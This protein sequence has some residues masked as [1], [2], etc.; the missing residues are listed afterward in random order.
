MPVRDAAAAEPS[1]GLADRAAEAVAASVGLPGGLDPPAFA[2]ALA[3]VGAGALRHPDGLARALVRFSTGAA[4]AAVEIAATAAGLDIEEPIPADPADRRFADPAWRGNP[5]FHAAR[6]VH[7]LADRLLRDV[8]AA[9]ELDP[10]WD[11]KAQLVAAAVAAAA[12][13]SNLPVTNPTVLRRA[14]DTGGRSAV[15]GLRNLVRDVVTNGGRPSQV[16]RSAFR[17]GHDLAATPG[18]VV[19]RNDLIELLQ[20]AP[21]TEQVHATPVLL[22]PPLINKYYVMDLAPGRSFAEW[23]VRHGHTVFAISY[24]N[25]DRSWSETTFEEYLLRGPVAAVDAIGELTGSSEVDVVG[26]CQG[27]TLAAMLAAYLDAGGDPRIRSLTLLVA[28]VDFS[29]PGVL[30]AFT[31]PRSVGRLIR[32]MQRRGYLDSREMLDTFDLLRPNDLL[33]NYVVSG[34]LLG[35]DPPAYD[36]LAWNA[37]GTRLPAAAHAQY[38]TWCY[39]ENRLAQGELEVAGRRLR[40]DARARDHYVLGAEKDHVV[41]W[42]TAFATTRLVR[43]DV[44]FVLGGSGH[45]AGIVK[46]PV[47][48]T[49]SGTGPRTYHWAGP[50]PEGE[51]DAWLAAAERHERSW[52]EDWATWAA[53][54]SSGWC[55]PPPPAGG[56]GVLGDAPGTYVHLV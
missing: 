21:R 38:L 49:V 45:I 42:R 24:R 16:D 56:G 2:Q 28:P 14:F 53:E 48:A 40:L 44:R 22:S 39:V 5:W 6:D 55:A 25:P 33:W 11:R 52:W 20:Y 15:L 46:P 23:A 12:A 27:G 36:V 31:D 50:A 3:R 34:W 26:L 8:V 32:R 35:E 19:Y 18:W 41:P 10:P 29:D 13:P 7:L 47:P 1:P 9:A 17:I 37:D 43:G 4:A 51:A 54:R 30:G